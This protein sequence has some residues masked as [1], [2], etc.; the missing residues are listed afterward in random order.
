M[1][2]NTRQRRQTQTNMTSPLITDTNI[3]IKEAKE[4]LSS[5]GLFKKTPEHIQEAWQEL[6]RAYEASTSDSNDCQPFPIWALQQ[7]E[8]KQIENII[9]VGYSEDIGILKSYAP[10]ARIYFRAEPWR[11]V[12]FFNSIEQGRAR[13]LNEIMKSRDRFTIKQLYGEVSRNRS[14]RIQGKANAKSEFQPA[15]FRACC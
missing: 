15:D 14:R 7:F 8:H 5:P 12:L 13:A 4:A 6:R 9:R 1:S 3:G 10:S 2:R 11:F